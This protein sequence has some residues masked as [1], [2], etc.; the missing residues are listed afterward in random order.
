M[1]LIT[2]ILTL[3][4]DS[5]WNVGDVQKANYSSVAAR[6]WNIAAI[7]SGVIFGVIFVFGGAASR[8]SSGYYS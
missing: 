7:V 3:Q 8:F 5:A 4:V 1:V 6:R 2:I